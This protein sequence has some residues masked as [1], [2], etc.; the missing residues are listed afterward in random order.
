MLLLQTI[1]EICSHKKL[2]IKT[3]P[4]N[5]NFIA[6]SIYTNG[7]KLFKCTQSKS[8][9]VMDCLNGMRVLSITWVVYAHTYNN[10]TFGAKNLIAMP[11]VSPNLLNFYSF[12]T[13]AYSNLTVD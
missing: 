9:N 10:F 5:V 2:F 7:E 11:E 8:A 12:K 3:E 4:R 13:D 6:F 1:F